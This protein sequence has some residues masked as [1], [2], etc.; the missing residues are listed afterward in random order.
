MSNLS[1]VPNEGSVEPG[2]R[3]LL[4]HTSGEQGI[5]VLGMNSGYMV[6]VK[7][8]RNSVTLARKRT[9]P[10]ELPPLVSEDSAN[11]CVAWSAQR[12]PAGINLGFLDLEPLLFHSSSSSVILTR[13]EWTPFQTHCFLENLLAPGIESGTSGSVARISD[14]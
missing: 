8:K 4:L 5:S 9:I 10:T 12:I 3:I 2:E 7:T 1:L 14:H 6:S 11:F 13:L